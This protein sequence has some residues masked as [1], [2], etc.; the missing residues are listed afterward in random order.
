MVDKGEK[1]AKTGRP[2]TAYIRCPPFEV[3]SPAC[4]AEKTALRKR[5]P[6]DSHNVTAARKTASV[7]AAPKRSVRS[8]KPR[9]TAPPKKPPKK[10][11]ERPKLRDVKAEAPPPS[12]AAFPHLR[13]TAT[14]GVF[15]N[16]SG[17]RVNAQGVL[18]S[19]ELTKDLDADFEIIIGKK[20][21]TPGEFLR[22]VALHPSLPIS[23]RLDAAKSAAPYT[24][25]KKPI[26]VEQRNTNNDIDLTALAKLPREKRLQ[27]LQTLRDVGINLLPEGAKE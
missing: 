17:A 23:M 20:L 8:T 10:T 3:Y 19:L 1:R 11:A 5:Q 6:N 21:E 24:D 12:G 26:S 4:D 15:I 9:A 16:Q 27:L 7:A 2:A 13:P 14:E 25:R 22:A 18:L